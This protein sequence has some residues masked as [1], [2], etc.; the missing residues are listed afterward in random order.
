MKIHKTRSHD[1]CTPVHLG[2]KA[3][4]PI[5]RGVSEL[6]H[7]ST[8]KTM[9]ATCHTVTVT[10]AIPSTALQ[11]Y[12][13]LRTTTA[14][15]NTTE[16]LTVT[17]N[18]AKHIHEHH[19]PVL[20]S[21]CTSTATV[22]SSASSSSSTTLRVDTRHS[23]AFSAELRPWWLLH[24][25]S[26][27]TVFLILFVSLHNYTGTWRDQ[28]VLTVFV[29]RAAVTIGRV[30]F[31][32]HIIAWTFLALYLTSALLPLTPSR[33][34]AAIF[35][36]SMG[37]WTCSLIVTGPCFAQGI[38]L[39]TVDRVPAI[40]PEDGARWTGYVQVMLTMVGVIA[41]FDVYSSK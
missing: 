34:A 31:A 39:R 22:A 14:W 17:E 8:S 3:F 13:D 16:T 32:W 9:V 15:L 21:K 24:W 35:G 7:Y 23:Q 38:P 4:F 26:M 12:I 18:D 30:F 28:F 29:E 2:L 6:Q 25:L 11:T 19:T 36:L 20:D 33:P 27:P 40:Q 1:R 37:L 41:E 5:A 10:K